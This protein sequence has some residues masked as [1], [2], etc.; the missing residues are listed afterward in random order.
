MQ[1]N[2]LQAKLLSV[3]I[4][5]LFVRCI[6]ILTKRVSTVNALS[7][8]PTSIK[9]APRISVLIVRRKPSNTLS[10]AVSAEE[11]KRDPAFGIS[12]NYAINILHISF[13]CK[14]RMGFLWDFYKKIYG[15]RK[16][17]SPFRGGGTAERRDGEVAADLRRPLSQPAADSVPERGAKGG[18]RTP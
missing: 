4:K 9:S 17:A 10:S 5:N 14:D 16:K 1:L 2:T 15:M 6:F 13:G 8:K 7:I 11:K 3:R 18:A 12:G